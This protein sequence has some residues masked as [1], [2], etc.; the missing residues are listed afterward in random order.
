MKKKLNA[1]CRIRYR[2]DVDTSAVA[3][4]HRSVGGLRPSAAVAA[5]NS[6]R[7]VCMYNIHYSYTS[8]HIP[9]SDLTLYKDYYKRRNVGYR[10]LSHRFRDTPSEK[11]I[12]A[13]LYHRTRQIRPTI[14]I[15][16]RTLSMEIICIFLL[17][18]SYGL[19]A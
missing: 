16:E 9:V 2:P 15:T 8:I 10:R 12:F 18:I 19:P 14:D 13:C 7:R 1:N 3:A 6:L 17:I 4:S 11:L 5:G